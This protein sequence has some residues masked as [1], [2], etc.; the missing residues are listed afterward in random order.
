MTQPK[1]ILFLLVLVPGISLLRFIETFLGPD[2]P[3]LGFSPS[4]LP[5]IHDLNKA[6]ALPGF[7]VIVEKKD[8][9]TE[10]SRT[11]PHFYPAPQRVCDASAWPRICPGVLE[12]EVQPGPNTTFFL[13][14]LDNGYMASKHH[15]QKSTPGKYFTKHH[16][17]NFVKWTNSPCHGDAP[18]LY[19]STPVQSFQALGSTMGPSSPGAAGH[20]LL[21]QL[22]RLVFLLRVLPADVPI[23]ASTDGLAGKF[24]DL[25]N[26]SKSRLISYD[27]DT[28]YHAKSLY[29]SS[30]SPYGV[31]SALPSTLQELELF[32]AKHLPPQ[33]YGFPVKS[34][35]LVLQRN[36]G[37]RQIENLDDVMAAV[38][39]RWPKEQVRVFTPGEGSTLRED[40]FWLGRRSY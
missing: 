3:K 31:V 28:V 1:L 8:T 38:R 14:K 15:C 25:L 2:G 7:S 13:A 6:R 4:S 27:K 36:A 37:V 10:P 9:N 16:V 26:I 11:M 30:I 12:N 18:W 5:V 24:L 39:A 33:P 19:A 20:Y 40:F 32:F 35:I 21:Q 17:F 34:Q 23:I 22:T 29:F